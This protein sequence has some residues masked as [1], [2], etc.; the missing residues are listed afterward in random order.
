MGSRIRDPPLDLLQSYLMNSVLVYDE[1]PDPCAV[2]NGVP[3]GFIL[4]PLVLL[5]YIN[6]LFCY[7]F[8]EKGFYYVNASLLSAVSSF[9]NLTLGMGQVADETEIWF[10]QNNLMLNVNWS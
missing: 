8:P 3:H 7:L 5:V 2:E 1:V 4:G 9:E 10:S 6:D